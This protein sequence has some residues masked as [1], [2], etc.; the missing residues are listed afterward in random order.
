MH[1]KKKV[2]PKK[3]LQKPLVLQ[4]LLSA[5]MKP[6]SGCQILDRFKP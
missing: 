1:D 6:E 2:Y 4:N 3:N 5:D